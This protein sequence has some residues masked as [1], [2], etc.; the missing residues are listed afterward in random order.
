MKIFASVFLGLSLKI[1][2]FHGCQIFRK[3]WVWEFRTKFSVSDLGMIMLNS[4]YSIL[5]DWWRSK[6]VLFEF[7]TLTISNT[8]WNR[9]WWSIKKCFGQERMVCTTKPARLVLSCSIIFLFLSRCLPPD[10]AQKPFLQLQ[11]T[12]LRSE[13]FFT[14][15]YRKKN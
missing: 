5:V 11:L 12:F 15:F 13:I 6:L 4:G 10:R 9:E 2:N 1:S 3:C 7:F 14:R 8:R